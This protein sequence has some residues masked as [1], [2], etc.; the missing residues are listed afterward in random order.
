MKTQLRFVIAFL[1]I[2]LLS[3]CNNQSTKITP[4]PSQTPLG[5]PPTWTP[6]TKTFT[7][8][9]TSSIVYT[10]TPTS[11]SQPT[12]TTTETRK[13]SETPYYLKNDFPNACQSEYF[14]YDTL[15]SPDT[16]WLAEFCY[17]EGKFQV[18]DK[19]GTK[20]LHSDFK[21]YY[22]DPQYPALLGFMR[23][24][25][26]TNDSQYI[27]FTVTPEQWMDGGN[28]SISGLAPTLFRMKIAN[29][30]ISQILSGIFYHSFSPTDRRLIEVQ[31]YKRP[32]K[33]IIHDIKTGSS[34]SLIPNSDSRY[35]QAG[36]VIW[37]P[38]GQKFIFVAAFGFEYG[39]EVS[40]PMIHS[41]IL[42]N[43][44][45]ASQQIIISEISDQIEP[46]KWDENDVITYNIFYYSDGHETRLVY[47]YDYKSK[48]IFNQSTPTP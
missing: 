46:I 20:I 26:W 21:N 17:P 12:P 8:S 14:G 40:E 25:H 5:L 45:D 38:D 30:E 44:S 19:S 32:V 27:Y 24:V 33:L 2:T 13:P 36:E 48:T 42:V 7:P 39:D 10:R 31:E 9:P 23:P 47:K 41:L 22:Y 34:E 1:M 6:D 29:G 18:S 28:I 16:N 37:S 43:L 35:S 3:A 11:T 15:I 4:Q